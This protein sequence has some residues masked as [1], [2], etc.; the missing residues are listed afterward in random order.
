M[1]GLTFARKWRWVLAGLTGVQGATAALD[2]FY[3]HTFLLVLFPVSV[4]CAL[5]FAVRVNARTIANFEL[6]ERA[7]R[8][9]DY[10][11]IARMEREIY[12]EAFDHAGAPKPGDFRTASPWDLSAVMT[13]L[14]DSIREGSVSIGP[15]VRHCPPSGELIVRHCPKGHPYSEMY[16]SQQQGAFCQACKYERK[17]GVR[18]HCSRCGALGILARGLCAMCY[19]QL[20]RS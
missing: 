8:R 12:G 2:L 17:R 10:G 7:K 11:H 20:R 18:T 1:S 3:W 14:G 9:P 19:E 16:W 13:A 5:M 15:M 6:A 4:T